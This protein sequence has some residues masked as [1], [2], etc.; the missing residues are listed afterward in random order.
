LNIFESTKLRVEKAGE[1][2]KMTK[3]L[4]LTNRLENDVSKLETNEKI[5]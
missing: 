5:C 1:T 3:M 4:F 2:S